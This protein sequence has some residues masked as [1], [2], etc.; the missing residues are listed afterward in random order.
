MCLWLVFLVGWKLDIGTMQPQTVL[1][2]LVIDLDGIAVGY[3][4]VSPP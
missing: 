2:P 1:K 3:R 4:V